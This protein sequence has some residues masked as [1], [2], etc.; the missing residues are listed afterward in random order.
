MRLQETGRKISHLYQLFMQDYAGFAEN[1]SVNVSDYNIFLS[2]QEN[3]GCTQQ[4]LADK[5]RVQRSL[6]T[7]IIKKYVKLGLIER[8]SSER[9]KSAYALYL[10]KSGEETTQQIRN[11]ILYLNQKIASNCSIEQYNQ[12]NEALDTLISNWDR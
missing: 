6:L 7:R 3:P 1:I 5:R 12:L 2:I 10:T 8:R 9:N 4:F 11:K